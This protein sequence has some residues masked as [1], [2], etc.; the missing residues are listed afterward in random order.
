MKQF[1]AYLFALLLL[2]CS[3]A[4][5]TTQ[6][7]LQE[8][9][10]VAA[11]RANAP[12][13]FVSPPTWQLHL[14]SYNCSG[15]PPCRPD[16]GEGLL[17]WGAGICT[18]LNDN[19][20]SIFHD[21]SS[22]CWYRM[23][24]NG[25]LRQWGLTAGSAFDASTQASGTLPSDASPTVGKAFTVLAGYGI[26][27]LTTGQ[28]SLY[29]D[30]THL[31][32]LENQIDIPLTSSLSC[33]AAGGDHISGG[34]YLAHPGTIFLR[35]WA[36]IH[37]LPGSAV[38]APGDSSNIHDCMI[39]PSWLLPNSTTSPTNTQAFSDCSMTNG[40]AHGVKFNY[41]VAT[42]DDLE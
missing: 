42:Y 28:V 11:L 18:S 26:T 39:L 16:G 14:A 33:G 37:F 23:N 3:Q 10:S 34:N 41:P 36:Y 38:S 13:H 21:A 1:A 35:H 19:D 29:F 4:F 20:G 15:G 32:T 22:N 12:G 2:P 7:P 30:N 24:L 6:I 31:P 27:A 9:D 17:T 25:D 5:A 40:P 8:I